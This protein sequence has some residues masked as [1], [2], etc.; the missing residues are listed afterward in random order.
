MRRRFAVWLGTAVL[1]LLPTLA[2]ADALLPEA[3]DLAADGRMSITKG[4]P[5]LIE[6]ARSGCRYCEK[7]REDFLKPMVRSGDYRG[8]IIF[9]QL[10]VDAELPLVDFDGRR[11][12]PRDFARRYHVEM[13]PTVL[14]LDAQGRLLAKPLVGL[15]TEDFYGA[16]LD[17]AI[18]KAV[19]RL[20]KERGS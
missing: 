12:A 8:R 13:T 15:T 18:D 11:I 7:V 1:A 19:A 6:M 20:R 3:G 17:E 10:H 4:T 9:R 5:I 16:F 14:L 2:V